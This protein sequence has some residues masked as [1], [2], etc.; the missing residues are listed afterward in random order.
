[1][2]YFHYYMTTILTILGITISPSAPAFLAIYL[3]Q[4]SEQAKA[5]RKNE[6][7]V[8]IQIEKEISNARKS[9][10]GIVRVDL[11][12]LRGQ[13]PSIVPHNVDPI[14][15]FSIPDLNI[16]E[17]Q[18]SQYASAVLHL[19]VT[20]RKEHDSSFEEFLESEKKTIEFNTDLKNLEKKVK[21]AL[22]RLAK[23]NP[24]VEVR[25]SL[26]P[27]VH[28]GAVISSEYAVLT[29]LN[30]WHNG[31]DTTRKII[32]WVNDISERVPAELSYESDLF[33]DSTSVRYNNIQISKITA[34]QY[35]V[36][37]LEM[38][39]DIIADKSLQQEFIRLSNT[40]GLILKKRETLSTQIQKIIESIQNR[41]YK[42]IAD[43]C[44]YK[45][46]KGEIYY[47]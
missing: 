18:L 13:I 37:A 42:D 21:E 29:I 19:N 26:T 17:S 34:F 28:N 27:L 41:N 2:V 11:E 45:E 8:D 15:N 40:A 4:Y 10:Y 1:M 22:D 46:Y 33:L 3:S 20:R 47:R 31:E 39:R 7:L 36:R 25:E 5:T 9:H 35:G 16:N 32:T 30:I 6:R 12:G 38:I 14:Q 23:S 24:D 43:C 44:P